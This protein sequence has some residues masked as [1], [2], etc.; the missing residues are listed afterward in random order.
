MNAYIDIPLIAAFY[1]F[2]L[3]V[4]GFWDEASAAVK[5]WLTHGHIRTPF[6]LKP[7]SCSLCMTFW[8]GVV[9]ILC[10]GHTTLPWL[11]YVCLWAWLTPRLGDLLTVTSDLLA[12]LFNKIDTI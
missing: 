10:T 12:K 9:Y 11:C 5:G 1:V 7:F 3:D 6:Y 4:S 8:T 2:A